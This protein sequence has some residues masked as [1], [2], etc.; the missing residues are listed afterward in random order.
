MAAEFI[1]SIRIVE[2]YGLPLSINDLR[3]SRLGSRERFAGKRNQIRSESA[4][5]RAFLSK[6]RKSTEYTMTSSDNE[7]MA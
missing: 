5:C 4:A 1:R 6:T 7:D 3:Y 2:V